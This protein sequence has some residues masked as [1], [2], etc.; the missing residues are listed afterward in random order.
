M[1]SSD[2]PFLAF[3]SAVSAS[4]SYAGAGSDPLVGSRVDFGV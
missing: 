3:T 2:A 4:E 1:I